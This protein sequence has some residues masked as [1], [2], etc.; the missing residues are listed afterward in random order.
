MDLIAQLARELGP[1]KLIVAVLPDSGTRYVSKFFSDAW[2][3]DNGL[4]AVSMEN[5]LLLWQKK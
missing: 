1:G 5:N 4:V 3:K 2:M